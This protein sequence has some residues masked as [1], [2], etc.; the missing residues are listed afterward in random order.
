MKKL[1]QYHHEQVIIVHRAKMLS[2]AELIIKLASNIVLERI[3]R[4]L[5]SEFPFPLK[6]KHLLMG[7]ME[8]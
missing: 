1:L 2:D 4:D 8:D 6:R 5:R 3:F 7:K